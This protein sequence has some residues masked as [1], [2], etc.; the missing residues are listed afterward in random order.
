MISVVVISYSETLESILVEYV[1][2]EMGFL[3]DYSD[4]DPNHKSIR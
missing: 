4:A 2:K 3:E 1:A